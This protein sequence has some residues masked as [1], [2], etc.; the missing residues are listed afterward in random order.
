M[1]PK[2][3]ERCPAKA[4]IQTDHIEGEADGGGHEVGN[5]RLACKAH[6]LWFA[7]LRYG[8]AYIEKRVRLRQQKSETRHK[9]SDK[10]TG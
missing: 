6:N 9:E 4:Y 2:T 5:L 7:Q 8:K 3:G 1:D 10:D